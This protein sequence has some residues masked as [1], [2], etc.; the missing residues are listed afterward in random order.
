MSNSINLVTKVT[1][2]NSM[3]YLHLEDG[4]VI[5]NPLDWHPWLESASEAQRIDVEMYELS[6]YFPQLDEGLDVEAMMKGMPPRRRQQQK[7]LV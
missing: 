4:R 1:Y 2:D 5:G 7:T 3:V 6:V